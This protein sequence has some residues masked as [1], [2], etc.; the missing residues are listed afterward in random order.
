MIGSIAAYLLVVSAF[1][2]GAV[3]YMH[4]PG[5]TITPHRAHLMELTWK[6]ETA[7]GAVMASL[8]IIRR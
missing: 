3:L 2:F 4:E 6:A 5:K 7:S 8:P 1:E